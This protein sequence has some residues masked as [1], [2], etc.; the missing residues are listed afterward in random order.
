MNQGVILPFRSYYLRNT[1]HKAVAAIESEY[2]DWAKSSES[3]LERISILDAIKNVDKKINVCGLWKEV[4]LS[5]LA[6]EFGKVDSN[7]DDF[8]GFK[9]SVEDHQSVIN[10][11]N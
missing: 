1:F 9:T 10:Y 5:P 3:L 8:E 4:E 7:S 11:Q 6:R 2:F